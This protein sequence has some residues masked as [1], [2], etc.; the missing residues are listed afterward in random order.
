MKEGANMGTYLNSIVPFEKYRD[1]SRTR[2]FVDKTLLINEFI[3]AIE[4]DSQRDI[5]INLIE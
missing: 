1:I 2:F 5:C 3:S 4:M